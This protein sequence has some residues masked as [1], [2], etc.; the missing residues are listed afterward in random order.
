MAMLRVNNKNV[1]P[2]PQPPKPL[3]FAETPLLATKKW[4]QKQLELQYNV[5]ELQ[6]VVDLV[7]EAMNI[8]RYKPKKGN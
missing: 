8:R 2:P 5:P 1:L 3:L 7:S 4:S 6:E